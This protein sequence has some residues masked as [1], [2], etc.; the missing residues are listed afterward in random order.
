MAY[1]NDPKR[2]DCNASEA[3]ASAARETTTPA[4][5][6]HQKHR[7][8]VLGDS[9]TEGFQSFAVYNT[10][11]S[12]PALIAKRLGVF[13]SFRYPHYKPEGDPYRQTQNGG[14]GP[15]LNL[16][17]LARRL[18]EADCNR[19]PAAIDLIEDA[20]A[21]LEQIESIRAYWDGPDRV[22]ELDKEGGIMHNLAVAG[23]D[24][25]DL[26]TR[27]AETERERMNRFGLL[28]KV[29][30]IAKNAGPLIGLKVLASAWR[31]TGQGELALT[32]VEAAQALGEDGGIE[33]LI[34]F[35]GANNALGTVIDL[36]IHESGPGYDSLEEKGRYNLW[37][38]EHFA[39]EMARLM[40][41][42]KGIDAKHV[43]WGTIP[44]VTI[45]PLAHGI[46]R[47][48][49]VDPRFFEY[50]TYPWFKEGNFN[51]S[52]DPNLTGAQVIHI[53]S[54]VDQYNDTIKRGV[55]EANRGGTRSWHIV[56]TARLFE[57]FAYRRYYQEDR[58]A[59]A[60]RRLG[61]T[62]YPLPEPLSHVEPRIDT[63]FF[64]AD[65]RGRTHGG[66]ITLD[67]VHPTTVAYGLL[68]QEFMKTMR[69]EAHVEFPN[70][71]DDL[72]DF[73]AL[74]K[75]DNLVNGPP[76]CVTADMRLLGRAYLRWDWI[77]SFSRLLCS[78][79]AGGGGLAALRHELGQ[80]LSRLLSHGHSE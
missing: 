24:V 28:E 58:T 8:V 68:A 37:R 16:E 22:N 42:V 49:E 5:T 50:Y 36:Q 29:A 65:A 73:A 20:A 1:H 9:L 63:Q 67:G 64:Q 21:A 4:A 48:L 35:I 14:W 62:N 80:D 70:P 71:N 18:Q 3:D 53:D 52:R 25:R 12:Y 15:A 45:A 59:D 61:E 56:D 30:P 39:L 33:T 47:R 54:Y 38:P 55:D 26:F 13:D 69:G 10:D 2:L 34:V 41:R 17:F 78:S 23:Y 46:M 75:E 7:L 43:L 51:E 6:A 57:R 72:V 74:L 60:R 77:R 79:C 19:T 31:D 11:L 32:P 27:T 40:E 66:L 76:K 44:H